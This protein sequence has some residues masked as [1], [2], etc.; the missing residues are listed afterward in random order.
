M[1]TIMV[2]LTCSCGDIQA[3]PVRIFSIET[4]IEDEREV[5]EQLLAWRIG[6]TYI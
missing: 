4:S 2:N 5:R 3:G 1:D 6:W